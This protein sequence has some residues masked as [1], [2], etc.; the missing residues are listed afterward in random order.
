M[1]IFEFFKKKENTNSRNEKIIPE[2]FSEIA[3]KP[4]I[5]SETDETTYEEKNE[6]KSLPKNNGKKK[7]KTLPKDIEEYINDDEAVKAVFDKCDINA[8]GGYRKGNIFFYKISEDMIKWCLERGA[9]I[10]YQDQFHATA[11]ME[12]AGCANKESEKQALLLI[13]NGADVNYRGGVM[14]ECALSRAIGSGQTEVVDAL[15]EAG[16]DL[17]AENFQH[18]TPLESAFARALPIDLMKLVPVTKM[19]LERGV[20]ASDTVKTEFLRIAKDFEFRRNEADPD[21]AKEVD[22]A[23]DKLYELFDVPRVPRRQQYDGVSEIKPTADTW[24]KQHTQLWELLVPGSGHANTVQGEVIRISGKISYEILDNGCMNWDSEYSKLVKAFVS[25]LKM[26]QKLSD[27]ES[28]E[29]DEITK[30]I[31]DKDDE[32]LNRLTELAVKWVTL[33]PM[34]IRLENVEYKR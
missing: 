5:E 27:S 28:A 13:K 19:L 11:L 8:Y 30:G 17:N 10:N 21:F 14:K 3:E 15:L 32:E 33:N 18:H 4:K 34:P 26:G 31:K 23:M 22:T 24:Q 6:V 7:R 20:V 16:A 25:Y 29:I 2:K 1:S 9:D 12:H